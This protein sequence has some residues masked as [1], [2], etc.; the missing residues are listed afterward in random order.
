M[1]QPAEGGYEFLGTSSAGGDSEVLTMFSRGYLGQ[2]EYKE[3]KGFTEPRFLVFQPAEGGYE[4][5]GRSS[6]AIA[7]C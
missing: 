5:L 7:K 2:P 1:F 6:A 4:F 3:Y